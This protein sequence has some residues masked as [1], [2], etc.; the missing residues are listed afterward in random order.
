MLGLLLVIFSAALGALS[1]FGAQ[2]IP[3]W[4]ALHSLVSGSLSLFLLVLGLMMYLV[5]TFFVKPS[6][7]LAFVTTGLGG[8]RVLIDRGSLYFPIVQKL[9]PVSLET[10]KLEVER[11]EHDALITKDNL[12]VDVKAEFYIKVQP[13]EDSVLG[14]SRSLGEKSVTPQAV[15]KL[16]FEKL[17]SAL[18]SVAA[19]KTL[20]EIHSQRDAFAGAVQELVRADLEQNGLTLESVTLSRLD[21]TDQN[22]LSDSNIFDAQGKRKITEIT[23]AARVER[24]R[25]EQDA[26]REITLMNVQTGREILALE[27]T[28]AEA[29]ASQKS[30]IAKVQSEMEREAETYRLEQGRQIQEAEI[31]QEQA[32]KIAALE[33]DRLI[34]LSDQEKQRT[35]VEREKVIA[36]AQRER[37]IT[38]SEAEKRGAEAETR[39]LE[40]AAQREQASQQILTVQSVAAAEREAQ[41]QL[42][43]AKQRIEQDRLSQQTQAEVA[44]F[45]QVRHAQGAMQAAKLEAESVRLKADANADAR[46]RNARAETAFKKV[47]V[48][49]ARELV[50]VERVRVEVERQSLENRETHSQAALEYELNKLRVEASRDVQMEMARSVA[51]FMARGQMNIYGSPETLSQMNEQFSKGM[52]FGQMVGGALEGLK[53]E[54]EMIQGLLGMLGS[55]LPGKVMN[56]V[57]S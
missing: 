36:L 49:I 11:H 51:Q 40:A 55:V 15:S 33:R 56:G 27:R 22:L 6:A 30:E 18:R 4:T 53:L 14:A 42:V 54:P 1:L 2:L 20:E 3:T 8:R 16:V 47:D 57:N 43:A 32:V 25:L 19:T 41:T 5:S 12:R 38:L 26:L 23:Q 10:M 28:R 24:N 35:N 7:N 52:G 13:D 34:L 17:V 50:E 48:D 9:V 39:V 44:A 21:Q 46:E 31:Y 37:A 29:E 45:A